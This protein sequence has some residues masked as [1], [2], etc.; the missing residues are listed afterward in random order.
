MGKE[1]GKQAARLKTAVQTEKFWNTPG[2][3]HTAVRAGGCGNFV[4]VVYGREWD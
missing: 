1:R 4:T 3:D 2:D